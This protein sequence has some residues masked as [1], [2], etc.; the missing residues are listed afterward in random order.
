MTD[1]YSWYESSK[2]QIYA[3]DGLAGIGKSTVARTVAQEAHGRGWLGAS[4]LF[5]K[6]EDDRKTAKLFFSTIAFQL[7]EYS[8][9]IALR[10]GEALEVNLDASG[11]QLQDQFRDLIIHPLQRCEKISKSTILIV[12]DALDECDTQDAER[13]LSLFLLHIRK[14]PNLKI[15]FTT[16]PMHHIRNILLRYQSHQLYRLHEIESSIV[17][18]DVRRYLTHGLSSQAVQDALPDLEPP[19]WVPSSSELNT[20]VTA[21]G[22]LFIIASTTIKFLLDDCRYDPEAQ[23]KDLMHA[24]TVDNTGVDPLCTLDGVYIQILSVAIPS[25]SSPD[26]LSRFHSVIGTIV[27]LQDPL[28]VRPLASLLHTATNDVKRALVHLQSVIYLSGPEETPRI[29]HKSFP[30]FITDEKRCS[31]D[32]RFHVSIEMQHG[33]IA[34]NCFRVMDEQLR[35]NIC[36]LKFPDN[37]LDNDEV[38]HLVDGRISSELQYA[39]L[40]W[41]TH[42]YSADKDDKLPGLLERF[43]FTHLLHWLEVLSLIGRL[44]AGYIALDYAMR[45]TVCIY[46]NMVNRER[47]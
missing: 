4:F 28:P 38:Q 9:E 39:C 26:I 11:K 44:E 14:V 33:R 15:F 47:V 46:I 2:S 23:M 22:K 16:R 8:K 18:G 5:S 12:I 32:S 29:Y 34:Q 41:A 27:L 35:A 31:N 1:I 6:S 36:D 24:I 17:E 13:L 19:P 40:H 25:N 7:S 30:D 20:L 37:Y 3:L 45:F 42:L 43:S 21:A 10:V